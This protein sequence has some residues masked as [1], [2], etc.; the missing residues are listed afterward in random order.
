MRGTP[1]RDA[2]LP[3]LHHKNHKVLAT[4]YS[5]P[6]PIILQILAILAILSCRSQ[7]ANSCCRHGL[8]P[9]T[10]LTINIHA[11]LSERGRLLARKPSSFSNRHDGARAPY[12]RTA[13]RQSALT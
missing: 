9:C 10:R 1:G 12:T 7:F 2:T 4:A 11:F 13:R 5:T 6:T 8:I 3:E